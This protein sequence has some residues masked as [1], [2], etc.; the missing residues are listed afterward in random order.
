[1]FESTFHVFFV[2]SQVLLEN[3]D[4]DGALSLLNQ[5]TSANIQPD[6]QLFN[7]ILRQAYSKVI[8]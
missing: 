7:T 4:F 5:M 2:I 6:I 3:E 8:S 1:M